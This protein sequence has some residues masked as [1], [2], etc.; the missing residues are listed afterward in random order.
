MKLSFKIGKREMAQRKAR[1]VRIHQFGGPE[2]L[3]IED[4]IVGMPGLGEVRLNIRAIGLNRTE[5]TLPRN[6]PFQPLSV[7]KQPE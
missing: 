7:G 4:V 1:S 6:H 5:I 3:R 2:V